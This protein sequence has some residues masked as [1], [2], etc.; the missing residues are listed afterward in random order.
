MVFYKQLE[1][2]IS[3]GWNFLKG[4]VKKLMPKDRNSNLAFINIT[5]H[6]ISNIQH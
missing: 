1:N 5:L 4:N 6:L 2:T 3:K